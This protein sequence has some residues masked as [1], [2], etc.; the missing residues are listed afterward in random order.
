[1]VDREALREN[2]EKLWSMIADP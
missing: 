2:H 1:M